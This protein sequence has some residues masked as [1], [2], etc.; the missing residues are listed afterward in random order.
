MSRHI[1]PV[2]RRAVSTVLALVRMGP[3][4]SL[5]RL[6]G[7]AS[8][9]VVYLADT[10]KIRPPEPV[11]GLEFRTLT[12]EDLHNL[13]VEDVRF[14]E[15]QLER[16]RRFGASY[17]HAV[18]ADGQITHISWLLSPAAIRRDIPLWL[19]P[20]E[21]D[22]EITGCET[23]PAF[24]GRG[25]YPFAICN[26]FKIARE[27]GVR[28]IFMKTAPSN[29]ASQSGIEKAG[30]SRAGSVV[31]LELPLMRREVVWRRLR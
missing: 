5:R 29:K 10:T 18:L 8:S 11:A 6:T 2:W 26:L 28:R 20:C 16:L 9:F 21:G 30:L 31:F 13:S 15:K 25:I 1:R 24:R 23:L 27:R 17:A 12:A 14:R 4:S 3:R 7:S 22:A 19:Q